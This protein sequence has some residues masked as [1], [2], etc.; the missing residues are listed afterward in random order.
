VATARTLHQLLAF[1]RSRTR[2]VAVPFVP[3]LRLFQADELTPLWEAST[4]VEGWDPVPF[5]GFAWAGGVAL[6]RYLLDRPA[7]V[8]GRA[9]FD[10]AT[11]SGL[12]ALAALRA[13]AARAVACDLDPF[14]EAAVAANA[15]LNGLQVEFRAGNPI[16][17]PLLG[18][19]V[20][21]AGDVF[22]ERPL[23]RD[24]LAWFGELAAGGALVLAGD[25]GRLYSPAEGL[26]E[27]ADYLVPTSPDLESCDSRHTSVL[28]ALPALA[29]KAASSRSTSRP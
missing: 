4:A 18:F 20:V 29:A 7:L 6:A 15:E 13:G 9:V 14:C 28:E 3:E 16:G 11:G 1:V 21:L 5:W 8:R 22:Y 23:A 27:R 26:V 19:D 17:D 2:P 10:F 25:P 24:A 12:V